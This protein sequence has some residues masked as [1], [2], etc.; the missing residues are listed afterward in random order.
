MLIELPRNGGQTRCDEKLAVRARDFVE[1][2]KG[3]PKVPFENEIGE[4]NI[5]L[6]YGY[7]CDNTRILFRR[8]AFYRKFN[9]ALQDLKGKPIHCFATFLSFYPLLLHL[10]YRKFSEPKP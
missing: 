7:A 10:C 8:Y 6:N 2:Q 4:L 9:G 1:L 5:V 3:G